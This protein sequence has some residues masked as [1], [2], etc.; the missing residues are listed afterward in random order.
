MRR[1][2]GVIRWVGDR[3]DRVGGTRVAGVSNE[4]PQFC[5]SVYVLVWIEMVCT[6]WICR[7][8]LL[9]LSVPYAYKKKMS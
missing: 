4:V 5:T 3:G 1:L 8:R 6:L 7:A 2:C 9:S